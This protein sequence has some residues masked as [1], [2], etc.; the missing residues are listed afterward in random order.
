MPTGEDYRLGA[1]WCRQTAG[2]LR[3]QAAGLL[4]VPLVN[5]YEGPA[6]ASIDAAIRATAQH[7]TVAADELTE[8]A[9]Q[10]DWRRYVCDDFATRWDNWRYAPYDGTE[11][12]EPQPPFDWV[13]R[14]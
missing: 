9:R 1:R 10:F 14:F 12:P 13:D 5:A 7:L 4:G 2:R 6:L 8:V 11:R 3:D